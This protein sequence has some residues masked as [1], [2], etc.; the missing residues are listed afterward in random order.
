MP[1]KKLNLPLV[2]GTALY[3]ALLFGPPALKLSK[4]ALVATPWG[5]VLAAF[6]LPWAVVLGSFVLRVLVFLL[7]SKRA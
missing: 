7:F 5:I 2:I 1:T 3:L 6:W 4:V